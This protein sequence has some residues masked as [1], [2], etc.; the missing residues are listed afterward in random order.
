MGKSGRPII[1]KNTV[2]S[3]HHILFLNKFLIKDVEVSS[4]LAD[5]NIFKPIEVE[6]EVDIEHNEHDTINHQDVYDLSFKDHYLL[7][8]QA[9]KEEFSKW[10]RELTVDILTIRN[11]ILPLYDR[12]DGMGLNLFYLHHHANRENY[13]FHHSVSVGLLSSYIAKRIGLTKRDAI[14]VGLA[15]VLS[16]SGLS[17]IDPMLVQKSIPI[18]DTKDDALKR[19]PTFSYR[20]IE[21]EATISQEIKLAVLQ[22]HERLDGSGYPLGLTSEKIHLYSRIISVVD[23]Y[24]ALSCQQFFSGQPSPFNVIKRLIEDQFTKFDPKVVQAMIQSFTSL[25]IGINVTLSNHEIGKIMFI[26]DK[27]PLYPMVQLEESQHIISLDN[28]RNLYITD[29][30]L[31]W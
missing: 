19:H 27:K 15:G 14:Q 4:K 28:E 7:V 13:I 30:L 17:K 26:D 22:H 5:G 9:F 23:E 3:E 20:L 24:H 21:S 18:L 31:D 6:E 29:L 8:V 16:D 12:M 25:A 11:M 1:P 10:E 2:L